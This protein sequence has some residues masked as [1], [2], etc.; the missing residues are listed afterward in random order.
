ME[1]GTGAPSPA[2][3]GGDN[4]AKVKALKAARPAARPDCW[5]AG[6]WSAVMRRRFHTNQRSNRGLDAIRVSRS[7][8]LGVDLFEVPRDALPGEAQRYE[9]GNKTPHSTYGV[10]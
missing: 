8:P 5:K 4:V 9:S 6:L 1:G 7:Q 10:R 2:F 3:G